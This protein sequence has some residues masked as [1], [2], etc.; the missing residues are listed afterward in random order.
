MF[1]INFSPSKDGELLYVEKL[2]EEN[3]PKQVLRDGDLSEFSKWPKTEFTKDTY[4]LHITDATGRSVQTVP[5]PARSYMRKC[6][7]LGSRLVVNRVYARRGGMVYLTVIDR[8][9]NEVFAVQGGI[10]SGVEGVGPVSL[11]PDEKYYVFSLDCGV[12]TLFL[13]GKQILPFRDSKGPYKATLSPDDFNRKVNNLRKFPKANAV[14][15]DFYLP[16]GENAWSQDGKYFF[17]Y[18]SRFLPPHV[19][20]SKTKGGFLVINV[21]KAAEEDS[22][23][24]NYV[25]VITYNKSIDGINAISLQADYEGKKLRI[26]EGAEELASCPLK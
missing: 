4:L 9:T 13:N 3:V 16:E 11:S 18:G 22:E 23:I 20:R 10:P 8:K 7:F 6:V 5:L 19:N 26:M 17:L 14:N 1:Y 2:R 25:S 21:E 12:P 24:K 15:G